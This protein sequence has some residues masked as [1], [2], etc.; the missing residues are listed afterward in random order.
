MKLYADFPL[1]GG[2]ALLSP[3]LFKGQLYVSEMEICVCV[4]VCVGFPS[5]SMVKNPLANAGDLRDPAQSLGL[6]DR[7]EQ[8]MTTHSSIFAWKNPMDRAAWRAT[9]H[10]VT[11]SWA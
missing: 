6:E 8:G 5:G 2:W 4:R 10:R 1:L 11:K 7:L 3:L 9:V